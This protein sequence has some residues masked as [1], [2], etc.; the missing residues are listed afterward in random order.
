[1]AIDREQ[2][3]A[4]EK[5][6]PDLRTRRQRQYAVGRW[7]A[8]AFGA[9]HASSVPQRG[10][11][12]AEEAIEAAQACGLT[13]EQVHHVVSYVYGRPIG[14]LAQEI[15]G[16][17]VTLLALCEAAE[18]SADTVELT[19]IERVLAKPLEHF[20]RRNQEK[21]DAGLV[22]SRLQ[23][24][25]QSAE[26]ECDL[27]DRPQPTQ[28]T[29]PE[30]L[31]TRR[32]DLDPV[33][34]LPEHELGGGMFSA[35]TW[36][37]ACRAREDELVVARAELAQSRVALDLMEQQCNDLRAGAERTAKVAAEEHRNVEILRSA[38]E[39][40][41]GVPMRILRKQR[42]VNLDEIIAEAESAL[43]STKEGV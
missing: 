35:D 18:F 10:M 14:E 41:L 37:A 11:R 39:R 9:E 12:L 16:V 27:Q 32:S 3:E 36:A 4:M 13:Q 20:K 34:I 15:G 17:S 30:T 6:M 21:N 22:A 25:A 33:N 8:D 42:V 24:P 23:S 40:I 31:P 19:E 38:L 43:A 26:A 28:R 5:A 29:V 7:C 2:D 1:M